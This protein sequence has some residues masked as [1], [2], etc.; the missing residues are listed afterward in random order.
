[1]V[2]AQAAVMNVYSLAEERTAKLPAETAQA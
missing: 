2:V 1:M